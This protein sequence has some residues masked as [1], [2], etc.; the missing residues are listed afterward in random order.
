[1]ADVEVT[2]ERTLRVRA[3]DGRYFPS[4]FEQLWMTNK[5]F[6]VGQTFQAGPFVATVDE[7]GKDGEVAAVRF[8][9][10]EPITS[11][12]YRFMHWDGSHFETMKL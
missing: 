3:A 9:F 6:R 4:C 7:L 2:G 11:D 5:Y 1:D 12:Q 10:P 8:T